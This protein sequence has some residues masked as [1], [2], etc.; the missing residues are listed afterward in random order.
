MKKLRGI[1]RI[2]KINHVDGYRISLLFNNGESR[3]LELDAFLQKTLRISPK[4]PGNQLLKHRTLMHDVTVLNTTIGW[5]KLG[6]MD[7]DEAGNSI[8]YPFELDPL[9]L[10]KH[11]TPDPS[12]NIAIGDMIKHARQQAKLTQT[13]LADRSGTTKQ[14]IS[15]LENNK[16]DVELLT[17][18]KIVEAG[19]GKQLQ[20]AIS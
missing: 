15:R 1:P 14:Y 3:Y 11:S 9:L 16:S 7:T 20:I 13:Q 10:F 8:W 2:L 18:K 4:S 17:L 12:H 5:P 6:V 19:L